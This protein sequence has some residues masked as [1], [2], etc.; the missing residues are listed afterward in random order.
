MTIQKRISKKGVV[1][2]LI[3]VSL[4]YKDGQQIIRSMTWK[5]DEGMKQKALEKE[6]NRQAILFEEKAKQD[7]LNE[8][9]TTEN[10]YSS[11]ELEKMTFEKLANE[12]LTVCAPV[13]LKASSLKRM[14]DC[15]ERVYPVL[16]K[17]KV[18]A[19]K[20]S[21][22]QRFINSL[23]QDGTNQRTGKGLSS[24][25]QKHYLTFISDVLQYGIQA[26]E[27]NLII[28]NPCNGVVVS[29]TVEQEH[30][31]YSVDETKQIL[32]AINQNA[33][34]DY[35]VFF[36][37]LVY[38]GGMRRG[39]VLGLEYKDIDFDKG[40]LHIRRTSN[41]RSGKG[42]YTDT[43]K[44]QSSYRTEKVQ[45]FILDLIKQL[46]ENQLR[47]SK[48]IGDQWIESDRL[49]TTWCGKPMHPNTPYT[50]LQRLCETE[51]I[52][53]KGIHSFRHF[54]A[55]QAINSGI[56]I[57]SVSAMLGHSKTSTTLNIY[58]HAIEN[59]NSTAIDCIADLLSG[60]SA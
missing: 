40:L 16:G 56:D 30:K 27:G 20:Y 54:V 2:Y 14:Q 19:V 51:G 7:Y 1:S 15:K 26:Y 4:G 21:H 60:K 50:F 17:L 34:I 22:I 33:D 23:S 37:I 43:L 10:G 59:N 9:E 18:K 57:K 39:E 55:T 52:P 25:T 44:T 29:K 5:P 8:L 35:K 42:V 41:Y 53:F 3:R 28:N 46:R 38:C 58:T 6:L 45:P 24:K 47:Q 32:C 12:W 31:V 49:F 13:K 36:N 48:K 11:T